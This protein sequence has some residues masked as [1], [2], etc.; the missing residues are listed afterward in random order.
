MDART[1]DDD[2]GHDAH[3]AREAAAALA[4]ARLVASAA[5]IQAALARMAAQIEAR[6][7]AANPV[8]LTVM[9]GGMFTA[10]ELCRRFTFPYELDFV[11]VTRYGG[12]LTGGELRWHVPLRAALAGRAV[13]VVDDVLDRGVTLAA[14]SDEL[15]R[16]GVALEQRAVLV[17]KE[18]AP[19]VARLPV[20]YVGVTAGDV[21]LFGCGMDYKGYWRGLPALYALDGA[22]S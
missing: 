8:V 4:R 2:T 22:V 10:V 20:D 7:G 14:L 15:A 5:T 18:P 13:L 11:H 3:A 9:H 16:I 12:A 1:R 6:L 19:P 21:F 17:V